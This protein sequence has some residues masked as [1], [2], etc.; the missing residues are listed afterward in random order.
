MTR[1]A[2]LVGSGRIVGVLCPAVFLT[3]FCVLFALPLSAQVFDTGT[4][5][6]VVTDQSGAVVPNADITITNVGTGIE[7]KLKTDN[8]GNFVAS[9]VPFG[10]YVVSA[11]AGGFGRA[12]SKTRVLN[13]GAAVQVNLALAVATATEASSSP[14]PP[15]RST[16]PRPLWAPPW[17]PIR[18]ETSRSMAE[19]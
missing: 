2:H 6:G 16:R 10:N 18:S 17:T 8:S 12:T 1:K 13:V 19:T 5:A 11:T 9:A 3:L 14:A 4:I 7:K 15:Q